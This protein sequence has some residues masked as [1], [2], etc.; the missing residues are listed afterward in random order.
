[1]ENMRPTSLSDI[2]LL[3]KLAD[4][5]EVPA[6]NPAKARD[7]RA[8]F[9]LEAKELAQGVSPARNRRHTEWMHALQSF[10]TIRRKELSPMYST[11][12]TILLVATLILGGGGATVAAAQ[13]SQPDQ[14]L[15]EIKILSEDIRLNAASNPETEFQLALEFANRRAIEI[16]KMLELGKAPSQA[17]Q[18][19][20]QSQVEAAIRYAAELPAQQAVQALEQIQ[21]RLQVHQQAFLQLQGIPNA[22]ATLTQT[23]LM[24]QERL[25]WLDQE[26]KDPDQLRD[27]VQ[28]RDQI[29]DQDQIRDRDLDQ[30]RL[31][32][33][34]SSA[35][36][37]T[38]G[39]QAA[40]ATGS[41]NPWTDETPTPG[42]GYGP[43]PGPEPTCTCT[44]ASG[45]G[46]NAPTTQPANN[47]PAPT[48]PPANAGPQG[49]TDS[50]AQQ[51]TSAPG[52]QGDPGSQGGKH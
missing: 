5:G 28:D 34:Q 10:F 9:L 25:Q 42:S 18:Q 14:P 24:L 19:R 21:A 31:Q 36:P 20:Y 37:Q 13:N 7:G 47:Q 39:T 46:P 29:R 51:P 44:P 35:S 23:R 45:N 30:Q 52:G 12:A 43:G 16:Q 15:Y 33:P 50:P 41:G 22:Q 26:L 2:E 4:L 40:P 3:N 1:M 32:D 48:Y 27:Q 49:P 8:R 38:A 6:R 11:L 17:V